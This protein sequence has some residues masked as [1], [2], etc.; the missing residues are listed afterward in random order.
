MEVLTGVDRINKIS[1]VISQLP[2][3]IKT[4]PKII[5]S[6]ISNMDDLVL[7]RNDIENI[8]SVLPTEQEIQLI[9]DAQ[10]VNPD[11]RFG[12]VESFLLELSKI[13]EVKARLEFWL[14]KMDFSSAEKVSYKG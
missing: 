9:H 5:R 13:S 6:L 12:D 10:T 2:N 8:L 11:R 7:N 4:Q 3:I 14:F 1:L